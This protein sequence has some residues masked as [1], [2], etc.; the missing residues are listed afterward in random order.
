VPFPKQLI[1]KDGDRIVV[2]AYQLY[3]PENGMPMPA[4]ASTDKL[5]AILTS[6]KFVR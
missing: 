5:E 6:F 1:I 4:G 3:P 2:V